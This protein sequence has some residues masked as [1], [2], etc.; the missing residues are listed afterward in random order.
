MKLFGTLTF[1]MAL[2]FAALSAPQASAATICNGCDYEGT[3]QYL[4]LHDP[5]NAPDGD[6]STYVHN[7]IGAGAL[8]D[9][10]V[11][12]LNPDGTINLTATFNPVA[13]IAN[14]SVTLYQ[15]SAAG[16]CAAIN[17]SCGTAPTLGAAIA[18]NTPGTNNLS[19]QNINL[20][21]G[22][23]AFVITGTVSNVSGPESYSGNLNAFQAV[24]EPATLGLLGL[25]LLFVARRRRSA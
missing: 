5:T 7:N 13:A 11:F 22:Q 8:S 19:L 9:L 3:S 10:W 15:V 2:G 24:P 4:G 12:D 25:G 21:A 17:T 18:T 16:V 1:A 14:F 23:Y 6:Q 20:A